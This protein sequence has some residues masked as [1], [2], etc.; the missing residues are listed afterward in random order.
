MAEVKPRSDEEIKML[1]D[2]AIRHASPNI[3][4]LVLSLDWERK[5]AQGK[6][7]ISEA[8]AKS[9]ALKLVAV[10]EVGMQLCELLG[11]AAAALVE[12]KNKAALYEI[13][14]TQNMDLDLLTDD[15]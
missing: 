9:L 8:T 11:F 14:K 13:K 15:N 12:G 3:R 6:C 4:D 10:R 7:K 2:K 5:R 1:V